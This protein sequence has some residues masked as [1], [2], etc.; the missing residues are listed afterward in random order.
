M[1]TSIQCV[2]FDLDNTLYDQMDYVS[3][4][5]DH[6]ARTLSEKY[7][8]DAQE[9]SMQLLS[10]WKEKGPFYGRFFDDMVQKLS[11]DSDEVQKLID[12]SH[13]YQPTISTYPA[14]PVV[15]ESLKQQYSLAIITDGNVQVQQQKIAAL[16][17][18]QYFAKIEYATGEHMKPSQKPYDAVL[19]HFALQPSEAIYVGDNPTVDFV[20]PNSMG[21]TTVRV[22]TGYFQDLQL[23]HQ[24]EA[25]HT[26]QT[27]DGLSGV[28]SSL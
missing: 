20:T 4:L 27:L 22:L 8:L 10:Y 24:H 1:A 5:M 3:G 28:M 16:G 23:D 26:I 19:E 14:V 25:A 11:I 12:I 21:M 9:T 17:I 2:I 7:T 18:E 6:I 13:S 15:L